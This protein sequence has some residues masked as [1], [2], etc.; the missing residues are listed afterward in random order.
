[1]K[2]MLTVLV[3]NIAIA[4]P[5][6]AYSDPAALVAMV[7][8]TCTKTVLEFDGTYGKEY[9]LLA[10]RFAFDASRAV[11][12]TEAVDSREIAIHIQNVDGTQFD[13][14]LPLFDYK[15]ILL[16]QDSI[17]FLQDDQLVEYSISSDK[18]LGRYPTYTKPF[19]VKLST[20]ARGFVY[21]NGYIYI[22][23]GEFGVVMFDVAARR[24]YSVL[25]AGLM[26]GSLAGAVEVKENTLYLLQGAYHPKGFNGLSLYDLRSG[27]VQTVGYPSRMG[28]VDPYSST[29]HANEDYLFVNNSGWIHAFD[30]KALAA[31]PQ[32]LS[33]IWISVVENISTEGGNFQK[34]LM[35]N[36]DLVINKKD[37][38]ACS[39]ISYTPIGKRRPVTEFRTIYKPY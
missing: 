16:I 31:A 32:T 21:A 27:S 11:S 20:R 10:P 4:L 19:E 39:S 36:G 3:V 9:D 7:K 35:V 15:R 13:R 14:R 12:V 5:A 1:M 38:V 30:L 24:P 23:H 17:W 29:M 28:V 18:I 34:F 25:N 2:T 6:F 22:A 33:P 26:S 8:E 37:V